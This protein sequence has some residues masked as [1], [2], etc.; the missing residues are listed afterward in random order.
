MSDR[1]LS[2][3]AAEAAVDKSTDRGAMGAQ[4]KEY[5]ID[6]PALTPWVR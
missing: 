6:A 5:G 1:L 4:I 2:V 3:Y